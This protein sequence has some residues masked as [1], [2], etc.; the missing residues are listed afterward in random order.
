MRNASQD[1]KVGDGYADASVLNKANVIWPG[2]RGALASCPIRRSDIERDARLM[3]LV[4]EAAGNIREE[5]VA[6]S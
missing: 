6:S 3:V 1:G 4:K 2:S 5:T